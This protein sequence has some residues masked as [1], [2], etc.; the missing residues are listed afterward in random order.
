MK[1]HILS[2][3]MA[4]VGAIQVLRE[5]QSFKVAEVFWNTSIASC[6]H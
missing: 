4:L 2:F 1:G 5:I 6:Q 3:L